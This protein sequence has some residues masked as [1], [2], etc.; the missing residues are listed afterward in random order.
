MAQVPRGLLAIVVIA[1]TMSLSGCVFN[2]PA[3]KPSKSDSSPRS[4][5]TLSYKEVAACNGFNTAVDAFNDAVK[6]N[7]PATEWA[8]AYEKFAFAINDQSFKADDGGKVQSSFQA[9][10]TATAGLADKS[11]GPGGFSTQ[12]YLVFKSADKA[13]RVACGFADFSFEDTPK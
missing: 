11:R 5:K 3:P 7:P 8:A 10:A 12:E 2:L 4:G 6:S 13:V 9:A 1:T